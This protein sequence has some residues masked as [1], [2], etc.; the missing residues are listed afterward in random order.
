LFLSIA[1]KNKK[2]YKTGINKG[3]SAMQINITARHLK[4]TDAIDTYVRQKV[5]KAGK[6]FDGDN[7]MA[8]VVLSVEKNR[9]ITEVVF[10]VGGK[11]F[12]AKEESEDL[13]ASIDLTVDKLTKQL[14]KQKEISKIHRS[15]NLK[16]LKSKKIKSEVFSLDAMEDSRTKIAEIKRFDVKPVSIEDAISEMDSFNYRVYMFLNSSTDKI[17]VL[18]RNDSG[19]LVMLEPE[20]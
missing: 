17:N 11:P 10:S 4:L 13:Y 16:V 14:R 12:R 5:A 3:D 1:F 15:E 9:Q 7:V 2:W 18:Y 20:F 6:F 19:S 8:H